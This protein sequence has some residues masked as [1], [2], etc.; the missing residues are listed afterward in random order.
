[1]F[2]LISKELFY[3]LTAALIIFCA[4]ELAWPGVVLA[5]ININWVLIFWLIVSIIVL[6][7]DRVNNNYD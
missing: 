2:Y 7:A 5:Y 6:A 1:M 4:L 3:T